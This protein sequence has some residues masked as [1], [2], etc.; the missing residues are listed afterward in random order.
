MDIEQE[1]RQRTRAPLHLAGW[2]AC[3]V[4]RANIQAQRG[5]ANYACQPTHGE[6]LV[7]DQSCLDS[8]GPRVIEARKARPALRDAQATE[9]REVR[10]QAFGARY[11]PEI[12]DTDHAVSATGAYSR[13]LVSVTETLL[14][15]TLG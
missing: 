12:L 1:A 15:V 8:K 7:N 2:D 4:S 6:S 3:G 13:E 14:R 9:R 11:A 5:V 10:L